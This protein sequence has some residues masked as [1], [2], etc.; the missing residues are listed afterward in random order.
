[1]LHRS[2]TGLVQRYKNQ[3]GAKFKRFHWW[4][5]VRYQPKWRAMSDAPSTM[6]V[7]VYSKEEVTCPISQGRAKTAARKEKGKEDSSSQSRTYFTMGG[8]M[9]TLKKL[10]TLFT[11]AQM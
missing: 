3:T 9:S 5:A 11:K 4:E 8:I 10:N 1:M 7:F 6:D 2:I